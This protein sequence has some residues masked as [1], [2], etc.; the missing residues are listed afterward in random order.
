MLNAPLRRPGADRERRGSMCPYCEQRGNASEV[1]ERKGS[2]KVCYRCENCQH[3]G[4]RDPLHPSDAVPLAVK[5]DFLV[6]PDLAG[7]CLEWACRDLLVRCFRILQVGL[8]LYRVCPRAEDPSR[9][10]V[11]L[12]AWA[13]I[14]LQ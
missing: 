10:P 3:V 13:A 9:V 14:A 1:E 11:A 2:R 8:A 6:R 7:P 12:G 4:R 5:P